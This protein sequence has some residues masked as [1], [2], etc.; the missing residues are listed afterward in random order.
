[1]GIIITSSESCFNEKMPVKHL[2]SSLNQ[3]FVNVSCYDSQFKFLEIGLVLR[4]ARSIQAQCAFTSGLKIFGNLRMTSMMVRAELH[5]SWR[6]RA[7]LLPVAE[8]NRS[9]NHKQFLL[10]SASLSQSWSGRESWITLSWF[11]Y[12]PIYQQNSKCPLFWVM[13]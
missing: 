6:E 8:G 4:S 5:V 11:L 13:R 9:C 2:A 1:M 7:D 12:K 10:L 3:H